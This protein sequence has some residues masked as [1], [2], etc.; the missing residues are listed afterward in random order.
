M[1][2]I[3][4]MVVLVVV[5]LLGVTAFSVAAQAPTGTGWWVGFTVQNT[6]ASAI[7]LSA[8]ALWVTGGSPTTYNS[9]VNI[10]TTYAVTFHP[11]FAG[12]CGAVADNGCRIAFNQDLPAGFEGSVVLSS[13]GPAVAI[14]Q[15]NNNSSGTVGAPGGNARGGYQGTAGVIAANDLFFPNVKNNFGGQTTAFFVQAAGQN[16]NVTITYTMNDG[17]VYQETASITAN[18]MYVFLPSA[19]TPSV[20]SCGGATNDTCLGGAKVT[21]NAPVA[22]TVVE[23]QEGVTVAEFV[24]S[25]RGVTPSDLGTT[26]VA[27][28]MKNDFFGGTTGASVFNADPTDT[29]TVDLTFTVTGVES[30]CSVSPGEVRNTTITVPPLASTVVS[31]FRNNIAGLPACTFFAMTAESNTGELI[32]VTV[33]ESRTSGGDTFKAV[34]TGFNTANASSTVFFP[35]E[36][37]DFFGNTTGLALVNAS[38]SASTQ[39]NVVYS[40][41]TG[42][43]SLTTIS[44]GPGEAVSLRQVYKG[45]DPTKFTLDGGSTLPQANNKYAVTATA[46][47]GSAV[48]VG[49]AQEASVASPFLDVFNLEGFSQ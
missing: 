25:T 34:Y 29:A 1:R 24:L 46:T 31:P 8:E 49:L 3:R 41:A 33:N 9:A 12:T 38:A 6:H 32:A 45:V 35:L 39:I 36:K 5:L 22:G 20:P 19:A 21:S 43:H 23:F 37:E 4:Y 30:G 14:A 48:I 11:G 42:T 16:A 44:L 10:P 47:N 26:I 13:D 18:R 28:T 17:N 15:V 27:P 7:N 40:G 2:K